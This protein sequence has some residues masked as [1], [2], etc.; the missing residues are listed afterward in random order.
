MKFRAF[1]TSIVFFA[2]TISLSAQDN[3]EALIEELFIKSGMEK[4]FAQFPMLVKLGFDQAASQ[5]DIGRK[6]PQSAISQIKGAIAAAFAPDGIKKVIASEC[7]DKLSLDDLHNIL[8]WLNS[9][10]GKKLTH[11]E[12]TAST[13]EKYKEIVQYAQQLQKSPPAAERIDIMRKLDTAVG[14][15]QTNVEVAMNMQVAVAIGIASSLPR[16]QQ[17]TYDELV[18]RA[19]QHRGQIENAVRNQTLVSLLYTY[20]SVGQKELD[21]YISFASSPSGV[22]YHAATLAGLKKALLKGGYKWGEIISGIFEQTKKRTD[23]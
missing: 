10:L 17:P 21:Q 1:L 9:P 3:K 20:Q 16:E 23:T 15:A 19:E 22:N 2:L 5:G 14:S 6:L 13:P 8:A 12:E 7:M 11:L 18:K 4:Q